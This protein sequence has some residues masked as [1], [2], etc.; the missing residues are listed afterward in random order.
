MLPPPVS[1]AK[2]VFTSEPA[3]LAPAETALPTAE[4]PLATPAVT[5]L[6]TPLAAEAAADA[7][8]VELEVAVAIEP[9]TE[10]LAP[11]QFAPV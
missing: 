2:A 11:G 10:E 4:A 3:A 9:L 7:G 6:T 5:L 1:G 8:F